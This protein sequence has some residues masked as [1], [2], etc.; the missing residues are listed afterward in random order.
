MNP[1]GVL[2][3]V[4]HDC[5]G[6][7]CSVSDNYHSI[8]ETEGIVDTAL[9]AITEE[10]NEINEAAEALVLLSSRSREKEIE[11]AESLIL[12]S[13]CSEKNDESQHPSSSIYQ[14]ETILPKHHSILLASSYSNYKLKVNINLLHEKIYSSFFNLKL[15]LRSLIEINR[16]QLISLLFKKEIL[17][18]SKYYIIGIINSA[19]DRIF[20][21]HIDTI[22][23]MDE[24]DRFLKCSHICVINSNFMG[25]MFLDESGINLLKLELESAMICCNKSI[26]KA[27]LELDSK[28]LFTA[29]LSNTV[30]CSIVNLF[31]N[32]VSKFIELITSSSFLK[33]VFFKEVSWFDMRIFSPIAQSV[34]DFSRK[35]FC[36]ICFLENKYL[37]S[38]LFGARA[39]N[40][41]CFTFIKIDI[42][43]AFELVNLR[44][45]DLECLFDDMFKK[46]FP[47]L[48]QDG[49]VVSLPVSARDE[50]ITRV[51]YSLR[52][53]VC[54]RISA[55]KKVIKRRVYKSD[56]F[57]ESTTLNEG[58]RSN[59]C[60]E[61]L[62][63]LIND[64][65]NYIGNGFGY[66]L[67]RMFAPICLSMACDIKNMVVNNL[68]T[69]ALVMSTQSS[70]TLESNVRAGM[71]DLFLSV[72]SSIKF[73]EVIDSRISSIYPYVGMNICEVC[74]EIFSDNVV[75][76]VKDAISRL[77]TIRKFRDIFP[78]RISVICEN[79]SKSMN[80][81]RCMI[82][83]ILSN[84]IDDFRK[85]VKSAEM[86]LGFLLF[87]FKNTLFTK[88]G[89]FDFAV[90]NVDVSKIYSVKLDLLYKIVREIDKSCYIRVM[91]G[92][93]TNFVSNSNIYESVADEFTPWVYDK[94]KVFITKSILV[95]GPDEVV[96]ELGESIDALLKA[97]SSSIMNECVEAARDIISVDKTLKKNKIKQE[98]QK[99][100]HDLD[101]C[102]AI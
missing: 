31:N 68:G 26:K 75:E 13:L 41:S 25:D 4:I 47:I 3:C 43:E 14:Q 92:D 87:Y 60:Y 29:H 66:Y 101:H 76:N 16:N 30:N 42:P 33:G 51:S 39:R 71:F 59:S 86:E 70:F 94:I 62:N 61:L 44:I 50:L 83:G 90:S 96:L 8:R 93:S 91:S 88:F 56:K 22:F 6:C 45:K 65:N 53:E 55:R 100:N 23:S 9:G 72:I 27:V 81:S 7:D 54:Y 63:Y 10:E 89:N 74:S 34:S 37:V 32:C 24:V 1:S 85:K 98:S 58:I 36:D 57:L 20:C 17:I 28:H 18:V 97:I 69:S 52:C 73:L 80:L 19:I 5:Y 78:R 67:M 2:S 40:K 48:D 99:T 79:K 82:R 64:S 38:M 21:D 84:S 35:I 77:V 11:T 95:L 12:L 49:T 15:L 46:E 102:Y